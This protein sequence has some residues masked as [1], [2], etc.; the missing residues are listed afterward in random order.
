MDTR[1]KH[2]HL[3]TDIESTTHC[4]RLSLP[5]NGLQFGAALAVSSLVTSMEAAGGGASAA[6]ISASIGVEA[7]CSATDGAL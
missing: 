6:G 4:S 1:S 2:S 5:I 3:D 7:L